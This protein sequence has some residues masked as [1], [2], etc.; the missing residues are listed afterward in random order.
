MIFRSHSPAGQIS[1]RE[2]VSTYRRGRLDKVSEFLDLAPFVDIVFTLIL[3]FMLT[4]PFITQWGIKVNLPAARNITT[5]NPAQI[6]IVISS[7][8]RIFIR[9]REFTLD[10]LRKELFYLA[11]SN[12]PVSITSDYD[13]S[14]GITL[15]VWDAAKEVG[16]KKLN[17]R[18]QL[19]TTK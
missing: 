15:E 5:L 9:G 19:K 2:L 13:A 12:Q 7:D 16:I 18:A 14:W 4:S 17:V 3:F 1:W 6:E 8:N 11:A 10:E